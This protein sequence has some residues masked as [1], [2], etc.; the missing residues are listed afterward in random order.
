MYKSYAPYFQT[1]NTDDADDVLFL[2]R[3]ALW[4]GKKVLYL[5]GGSVP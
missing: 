5:Q 4:C 2:G 1:T 3:G